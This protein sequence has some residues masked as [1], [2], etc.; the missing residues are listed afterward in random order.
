MTSANLT[1]SALT[2]TGGVRSY[3]D[4][5]IKGSIQPKGGNTNNF[6]L[7]NLAKYAHTLITAD[8][9]YEGDRVTD[10]NATLYEVLH[11]DD[12]MYL[13][14]DDSRVAELIKLTA[15]TLKTLTLGDPDATTGIYAP[16]YTESSIYMN[17]SPKGQ[18]SIRSNAGYNVRFDY[19]GVTSSLI[20]AGDI[21]EDDASINYKVEHVT[22]YKTQRTDGFTFQ[23]C[24]L[25][26]MDYAEQ[27]AASGTWHLDSTSVKTDP[28]NRIKTVID[29][30]LTAVN[31]KKDDGT[32]NASTAT[33]FSDVSYPITR[34]F[35]TKALDAVAVIS[36]G[37]TNTLYTDWVFGHKPYGFEEQI[38]IEIYAINKSGVTASNLAEKYEQEIRRIFTAYDPYSNVRDLETIEPSTVDLGYTLMCKTTI[39]IKYKRAND[40][41]T[42]S[43]PTITWG[44]S[45]SATG[46][47]TWP[48]VT[49]F[50]YR[51]TNTGEI[52]IL[53]PGRLGEIRQILG[54]PDFEIILHSDMSLEPIAKT[55][56][57]AQASTKTDDCAWEVF[58]QIKFD[59]TTSNTKIYQTFN[60]NIG[61]TI[62]VRIE[63]INVD[64][65]NLAVTLRRYSSTDQ[66][67]G[68]YGAYYGN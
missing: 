54:N 4:T 67:G 68:T 15:M 48:N 9:I 64:G 23:V 61:A 62:P 41:Y 52:K 44:S 36:R 11:K 27:P 53:P 18:T 60:A 59:G 17:L 1:R 40:D 42:A 35:L 3:A 47:Y 49:K 14:Q 63:N 46:T 32:T 19:V 50:E 13:D 33:M 21:I 2:V 30:Y 31:I 43:Y 6:P 7:S 29:T 65:E 34:L 28:R 26:Q 58:N 38:K 16:S 55:W 24:A 20:Y 25:T 5:T 12:Y 22:P 45:T 57:R 8:T 66:S 10:A 51:D 39:N 56:K 37:S